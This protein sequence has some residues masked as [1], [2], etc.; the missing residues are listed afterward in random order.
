LKRG[1]VFIAVGPGAVS[2]LGGLWARA[3]GGGRVVAGIAD[4]GT[5]QLAFLV[6]LFEQGKFKP[7]IDKRYPLAE[8][9]AAH[10]RAESG[11]KRGNVVIEIATVG[12]KAG[13]SPGAVN[14]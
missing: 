2:L 14:L 4:S 7:V 6:E 9:V 10:R 1:G 12:A 5:E 3:T 13:Q 8:I 11:H